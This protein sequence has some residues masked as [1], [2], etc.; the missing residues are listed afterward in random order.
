MR[1]SRLLL[2]IVALAAVLAGA[3]AGAVAQTSSEAGALNLEVTS[4]QILRQDTREA[5]PQRAYVL[6]KGQRYQFRIHY[7]VGGAD[8]IRTG[9]TFA[10]VHIGT[11]RQVDV[12]SRTFDPEGPGSYSEYSANTIPESWPSG[13]YRLEW[14][15]RGNAVN[16]TSANAEDAV[17]F[18]VAPAAAG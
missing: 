16:A 12:D 4:F 5:E 7:T 18:L 2:T 1:R 15:L 17:T 13:A 8:S 3:G 11:G 6:R 10:F 14:D 9:H